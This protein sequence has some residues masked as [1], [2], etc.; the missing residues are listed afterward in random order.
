MKWLLLSL[1][2]AL[3]GGIASFL[4]YVLGTK[5]KHRKPL[6]VNLAYYVMMSAIGLLLL[7]IGPND[8]LFK[9]YRHDSMQIMTNENNMG[10]Y[11]LVTAVAFVVGNVTLFLSY[12]IAPNPG[13]CDGIASFSGVLVFLYSI[14]LL[15]KK[16]TVTHMIGLILVVISVFLMGS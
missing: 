14:L 4:I 9:N 16:Y 15:G 8:G 3:F 7:G 11:A 13:L 6:A 12:Y 10:V 1:A 5:T 2:A